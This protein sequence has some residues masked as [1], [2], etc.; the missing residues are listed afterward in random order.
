MR[1][2]WR[3][4]PIWKGPFSG[5]LNA[6]K[7][8]VVI[9]SPRA[10]ESPHVRAEIRYFK[11]HGRADRV[12][13]AIIEGEPNVS[14]D[15]K[16]QALGFSASQECFPE[17]MRHQVAPDGT[18]REERTEPIAADFRLGTG[19]GWVSQEAYRLVLRRAGVGPKAIDEQVE[20]Y[21][22]RG[23]LMKLKV[24]AGILGVPPWSSNRA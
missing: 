4:M 10:V 6:T 9:C 5:P 8:L 3:W 14:W 13:A 21:R 16:K 22:K 18:L 24:I 1:R 23:E 2:N 15:L 7:I 17:P 11:Q 20:E 19:Q 12:L